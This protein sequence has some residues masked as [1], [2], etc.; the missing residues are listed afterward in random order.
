MA[1]LNNLELK[2]VYFPPD[3]DSTT[4]YDHVVDMD[5]DEESDSYDGYDTDSSGSFVERK[6]DDIAMVEEDN[7]KN[8]HSVQHLRL[9]PYNEYCADHFDSSLRS[10]SLYW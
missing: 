1:N 9:M 5:E 8:Y 4:E 7:K 3:L 10:L 2:N 6:Y